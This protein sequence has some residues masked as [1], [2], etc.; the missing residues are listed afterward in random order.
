VRLVEM[1]IN[2]SEHSARVLHLC[3]QCG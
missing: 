1:D 2:H 3:K